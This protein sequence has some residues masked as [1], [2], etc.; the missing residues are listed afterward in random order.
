MIKTVALL[1]LLVSPIAF[2]N[3]YGNIQIEK[4]Q[5]NSV[6]DGDTFVVTVPSWHPVVGKKIDIRISGIDTPEMRGSCQSEI[7]LAR[8]AKQYLIDRLRPATTIELRS[9]GRDKYF[10]IDAQ[11]WI[12]G[13]NIS[14]EMIKNGLARAYSGGK[15]ESWCDVK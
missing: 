15:K 8:K 7:D 12:N 1:L 14:D 6:Y 2:A 11:L 9:L 5:I 13:V 4:S 10:R 3:D